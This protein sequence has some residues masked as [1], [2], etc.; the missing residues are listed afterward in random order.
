MNASPPIAPTT[1]PA[2]V[3]ADALPEFDCEPEPAVETGP[4]PM[5]AVSVGEPI[6]L[7]PFAWLPSGFAVLVK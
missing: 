2:I 3:P 7:S 6:P 4:P 5:M 1:L